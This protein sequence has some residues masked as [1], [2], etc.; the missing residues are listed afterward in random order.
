MST[1]RLTHRLRYFVRQHLNFKLHS[2][3]TISLFS[4]S[5]QT[6]A[7]PGIAFTEDFSNNTFQDATNSRANWSTEQQAVYLTWAQQQN[8]DF[9]TT[10]NFV[11]NET[12]KTA[13]IV[14][15]D[16]D[17]DGDIDIIVANYFPQF[18]RLYR[19]DGNGGFPP[20]GEPIGNET[21]FSQSLALGDITGDGNLDLVVGSLGAN[22]LY[23]NNG[24]GLFSLS[25]FPIGS[26]HD[27]TYSIKLVDINNDGLLDVI[28]GNTGATNKLYLND[29]VGFSTITNGTNIGNEQDPTVSLS[30]ADIDNDGD[31][32]VIA[33]NYDEQNKIYFNIADGV[34]A[35]TGI[36]LDLVV[37]ST[38]NLIT[39]DIDKDGDIDILV[40]NASFNNEPNKLYLNDGSGSFPNLGTPIGIEIDDT[41]DLNLID[42]DNDGDQDLLVANGANNKLYFNNGNASFSETGINIT[43][44]S[45]FSST[46]ATADFDNDGDVDIFV[47][48]DGGNNKLYIQ[49]KTIGI[50]NNKIN[51]DTNDDALTYSIAVGDIN[52]DGRLDI[53]A[54]NYSGRNKLY[55][56][57]GNGNFAPLNGIDI[58]LEISN[59]EDIQLADIDGDGSLDVL[60]ANSYEANLLYVNN[61][62]GN[63][64]TS[65]IPIGAASD[66]EQ[67]HSLAIGD[68][69]N[70]GNLDVI[71]GNAADVNKLYL[72]DGNG[73]F[74]F[75]VPI[76]EELD[77]SYT[78]LLNDFDNNGSLDL[79]VGNFGTINKFYLND[80]QGNFPLV[81]TNISEDADLTHI[82]KL[83]DVNNDGMLDVVAGNNGINKVY[84][85][86]AGTFPSSGFPLGQETDITEGLALADIDGDGDLD[87][88]AGNVASSQSNKLYVNDGDG[89][90]PNIGKPVN[91]TTLNTS[92]IVLADINHDG[93]L[94]I[95]NGTYTDNTVYLNEAQGG[96]AYSSE[97]I[98]SIADNTQVIEIG[99]ID[100]D[101][102]LDLIAG[103]DYEV[104]KIY[105]N[106][107]GNFDNTGTPI[108]IEKN[109]TYDLA[110]T[111]VDNDGDL[112]LI[113][114]NAGSKN[115]LHINTG[116]GSYA[117]GTDIDNQANDSRKLLIADI[118]NNGFADIIVAN[119]NSPNKIYYNN[120]F[121]NYPINGLDIGSDASSTLALALIDIDND[122]KPELITGNANQPN[123]YHLNTG[124]GFDPISSF[125]SAQPN[126]TYSF[127]TGDIDN[128]GD[129]DLIEG[130]IGQ[131]NKLYLNESGPG[132]SEGINIGIEENNTYG[133]ILSDIDHD[134]DLDL[135]T[136]TD[137][138]NKLYRNNGT[139]IFSSV[140][141]NI[142]NTQANT[143]N[144]KLADI[145]GDGNVDLLAANYGS[146]NTLS[147]SN[148]AKFQSHAN[149]VQSVK[150]NTVPEP[151][152]QTIKLI[153]E[154]TT[155]TETT[156][157]TYI[158]Y[159]LSNDGGFKWYQ[160]TSGI[161][162]TFPN[163]G[164]EDLRWKA[165]L[166]SLSP[167]ITPILSNIVIATD[168]DGDG[169][170]D[171][172]D[173]CPY[174]D[175][176][177]WVSEPST[178]FDGDGCH[179][180]LEDHDD[181]NDG[182]YDTYETAYGLD[183]LNATGSDGAAGDL[184]NDG[185]TNL[186][187]QTSGSAANSA[188][189][190]PGILN[191]SNA[192]YN[193][194]EDAGT[195]NVSVT[196]TGGVHGDISVVCTSTDIEAI[197]NVDFV[198]VDNALFW[199]D[200]DDTPKNCIIT[201]NADTEIEGNET[202]QI[203]LVEPMGGAKLG[204]P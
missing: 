199:L 69:N 183:P 151:L 96:F 109:S 55:I 170:H 24:D 192:T 115:K 182:L 139:G 42:M 184:D 112:D 193:V 131:T 165:E 102:D 203:D 158:N 164:T 97:L 93:S 49:N 137:V 152:P 99:D 46:I 178:D 198:N 54:G 117:T 186:E 91:T 60:V 74:P 66:A 180:F 156:R 56:N 84:F 121:G 29:G 202:F 28:A 92:S 37:D 163:P 1:Y 154:E 126:F 4:L 7:A 26:E 87:I 148:K 15:G 125:F 95:I 169:I 104:N 30:I 142:S 90:Y 143:H 44:D 16:I 76:G 120:G 135:I 157:N 197:A 100:N 108:G 64:P 72:N 201:I 196:R 190:N 57:N 38:F 14:L 17:N 177:G 85:S 168:I 140:G 21:E 194:N 33:G 105:F 124:G 19:N 174:D 185:F 176:S 23:T 41:H 191:F 133:T 119:Y 36:P 155:K 136:G 103:N 62:Q 127:A 147:L 188:T 187:E 171:G 5:I 20:T 106:N 88:L 179:D 51:I 101:G 39:S 153:A 141:E 167:A 114:A 150:V 79:F 59:T 132:F 181:D 25:G 162:F 166:H 123:R 189:S 63:F 78:V 77:P 34:F 149:T 173:N 31:L 107:D 61:G 200:G 43:N 18:N 52:G 204:T 138:A 82:I 116:A 70:D 83:G 146:E 175:G 12:E 9:G 160:V 40:G 11:G 145:N 47:G 10:G 144:I 53:V 8:L 73:N 65:G 13:G 134:G 172:I 89:R 71:A 68:V 6:Y 67:T 2:L 45:D 111:D 94:D 22:R 98:D 75:S 110:L 161:N 122:G 113:V 159:Y 86:Y 128:D 81:G 118:N 27:Q 58:G 129:I 48:N 3:L 195:L 130:N 32:D 50:S 80:G 35:A